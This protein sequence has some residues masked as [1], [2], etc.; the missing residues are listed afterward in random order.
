V[1]EETLKG[2]WLQVTGRAPTRFATKGA[3]MAELKAV[4][5]RAEE[6]GWRKFAGSR[7]RGAIFYEKD[8]R[9]RMV[10][11]QR[12]DEDGAEIGGAGMAMTP[13]RAELVLSGR[14][15]VGEPASA[16]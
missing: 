6:A 12:C 9:R 2:A 14:F 13:E 3:A 8:G 5:D 10:V 11:V 15:V 7:T 4:C 16:A 1:T